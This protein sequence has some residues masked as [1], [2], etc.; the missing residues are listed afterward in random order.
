[1]KNNAAADFIL[2]TPIPGGRRAADEIKS[3]Q[4]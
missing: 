3:A 4:G 1:M 2:A